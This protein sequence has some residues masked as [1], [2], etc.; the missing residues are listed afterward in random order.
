M[1][2]AFFASLI[3]STLLLA[4]CSSGPSESD[5]KSLLESEVKQLSDALGQMGGADMSDMLKVDIHSVKIHSCEVVRDDVYNCD[6]EVD[7]TAPVVG[8][9][10][11]RSQITLAKSDDGWVQA[12]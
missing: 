12:R 2:T 6:I 5:I 9:S 8:R 1:R 4:A 11:D 3:A 10:T 7:A